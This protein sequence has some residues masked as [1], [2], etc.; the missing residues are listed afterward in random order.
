MQNRLFR[1]VLFTSDGQALVKSWAESA[2]FHLE[3]CNL[4]PLSSP[5][6]ILTS[7]AGKSW[8]GDPSIADRSGVGQ[9][10][11]KKVADL[12]RPT[13]C[14]FSDLRALFKT[15]YTV[16]FTGRGILGQ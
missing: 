5:L 12:G 7:E 13:F 8:T 2:V 16:I 14:L 9:I 10:L 6:K 15:L 11:A 3:N 1:Q 4:N